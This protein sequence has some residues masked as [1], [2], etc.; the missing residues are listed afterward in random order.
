MKYF[1]YKLIPPR[2]NFPAHITPLEADLM[3]EH[4]TYWRSMIAR[5]MVI[6]FGP[7]ADSNGSYGICIMRL[8]GYADPRALAVNDPCISAN[9]GFG[10]EIHPMPN[11]VHV[12]EG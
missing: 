1:L 10:F 11:V 8:D 9:M 5:G 12:Q 7:V 2:P 6:A 4:S 3:K